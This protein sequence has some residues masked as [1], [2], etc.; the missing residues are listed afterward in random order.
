MNLNRLPHYFRA[1]CFVAQKYLLGYSVGQTPVFDEGGLSFFSTAI[2]SSR[3]YLEYGSGGSTVMAAKY[4]SQLVSVEPDPVF[5]RAVKKALPETTAKISILTPDIGLTRDWGYPVFDVPTANRI[6]RWKSLPQAPWK[7]LQDMPDLVLVDGRFRVACALQSLLQIDRTTKLL[8]DD[9]EGR[10]Y[11]AI[12]QFGELVAMHGC[13]AE[14]RKRSDF[15]E[16]LCRA[17]LD[18]FYADPR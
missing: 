7:V 12:E 14:F 13:M 5:A 11:S 4:V 10:D 2:R 17:A 1:A 16:Q 15:D 9:Y 18:R 8:V 3:I 6:A